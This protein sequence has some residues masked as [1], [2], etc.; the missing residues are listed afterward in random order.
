MKSQVQSLRFHHDK[1]PDHFRI[2]VHKYLN[3]TFDHP[4]I[5]RCEPVACPV[6]MNTPQDIRSLY[7]Y[8]V[9]HFGHESNRVAL[10]QLSARTHGLSCSI[11]H[12]LPLSR[13]SLKVS[14]CVWVTKNALCFV[15]YIS[16]MSVSSNKIIDLFV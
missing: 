3:A 1:D 5:G 11:P 7:G 9:L 8:I 10:R 2:E 6:F 16:F 4:W 15:H 12:S 14:R 13:R